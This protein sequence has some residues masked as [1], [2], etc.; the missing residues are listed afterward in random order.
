LKVNWHFGW[1]Y[2]LHLQVCEGS[3]E[4]KGKSLHGSCFSWWRYVGP[5]LRMNFE[6]LHSVI[7]QKME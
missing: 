6:R 3:L 1:T 4:R 5:K 7:S 2:R